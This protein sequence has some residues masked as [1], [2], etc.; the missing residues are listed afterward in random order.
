MS[1]SGALFDSDKLNDVSKT[2]IS[3]MKA[4]EVYSKLYEWAKESDTDFFSLISADPDYTVNVLGIDRDVLKPRRDIAK[5]SE[6]KNYFSYM[7]D[8]VFEPSYELPENIKAEDARAFLTEYKSVYSPKDDRQQWFNRIKDIC[9]ALGFAAD[10]KE[11]KKNPEAYKGSAGDLSSVLRIA[12]TGR[13]NTPDLC[14][15]MQVLGE[16]RCF[17]RIDGMIKNI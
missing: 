1:V 16:K 13:R 8:S 5:W 6:V 10:T 2:V 17:E 9:P 4:K 14:S 7:F 15:I 3:K 12:V 11:Y